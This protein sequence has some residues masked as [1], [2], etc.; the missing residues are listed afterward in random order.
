MSSEHENSIDASETNW[1]TLLV[2]TWKCNDASEAN[3]FN[4]LVPGRLI[5]YFIMFIMMKDHCKYTLFFTF[6]AY[7]F[8]RF[9]SL[10]IW[11][12]YLFIYKG[13]WFLLLIAKV[14]VTA[15]FC[16]KYRSP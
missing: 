15:L 6:L 10:F 2:K 14:D 5:F 12:P 7:Y 3:W 8:W 13:N 4:L 16:K 1:Y 9:F 11:V